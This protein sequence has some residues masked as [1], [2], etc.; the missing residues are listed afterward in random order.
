MSHLSAH[1]MGGIIYFLSVRRSG[2]YS[3]STDTSHRYVL[4]VPVK[5]SPDASG[6]HAAPYLNHTDLQAQPVL[7]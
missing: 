3:V 4:F 2:R 5:M 7:P 1:I 6:L